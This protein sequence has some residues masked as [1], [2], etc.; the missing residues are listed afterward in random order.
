MYK[1]RENISIEEIYRE[2]RHI[3]LL[4]EN[5]NVHSQTQLRGRSFP[6]VRFWWALRDTVPPMP[7]E[8]FLESIADVF[9]SENVD[10]RIED[11]IQH[12]HVDCELPN[13]I[14]D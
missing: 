8:K 5:Q 2:D 9:H 10:Q 3:E 13:Q 4:I 6:W 11:A 14:A 7:N 12:N 1:R